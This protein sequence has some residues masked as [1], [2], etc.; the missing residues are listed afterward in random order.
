MFADTQYEP[1]ET[2]I[3]S[4][5][6]IQ[7]YKW[8]SKAVL[9]FSYKY[10]TNMLKWFCTVIVMNRRIKS[11]FVVCIL[12][13]TINHI[14]ATIQA[15]NFSTERSHQHKALIKAKLCIENIFLCT[16]K[17]QELKCKERIS[18]YRT[19]WLFVLTYAAKVCKL[20]YHLKQ[21]TCIISKGK[22]CVNS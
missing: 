16:T 22:R 11:L 13:F 7:S 2:E 1:V 21:Y 12:L 8:Y 3:S 17:T 15:L 18:V 4:H 9:T 5:W 20:A 6:F 19:L 10:I 14:L